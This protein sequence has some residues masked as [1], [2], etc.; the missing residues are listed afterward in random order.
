M[1]SEL[2]VLAALSFY[3]IMLWSQTTQ[4]FNSLPQQHGLFPADVI[5]GNGK[6]CASAGLHSVLLYICSSVSESG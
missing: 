1:F 5:C 2:L 3:S 6:S 4:H